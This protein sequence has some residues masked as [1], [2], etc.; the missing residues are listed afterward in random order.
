MA[1]KKVILLMGQSNAEGIALKSGLPA[2]LLGPQA[3]TNVWNRVAVAIE[4]LDESTGNNLSFPLGGPYLTHGP[5]LTL[6]EAAVAEL[7][8]ILLYKY[9]ISATSLGD[10]SL[11]SW[12][13]NKL[14]LGNNLFDYFK[15]DFALFNTTVEG[16]GDTVDVQAMF[17]YQGESDITYEGLDEAYLANLK[18]FIRKTRSFI[19]EGGY[20]TNVSLPWVTCVVADTVVDPGFGYLRN[21][22]RNVRAAQFRAGWS[23]P[24]YRVLDTNKF[25]HVDLAHLTSQGY[26]DCGT[27]MWAAYKLPNNN[28]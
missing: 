18:Y 11:S 1:V 25:E 3:N 10:G 9:A 15:T 26:Q 4:Q 20:T 22:A 7:G 13:P 27:A 23:D 21:P 19:Q 8:E 6:C 28:S 2:R 24:Y 16:G 14:P 17:W 5:E 12:H